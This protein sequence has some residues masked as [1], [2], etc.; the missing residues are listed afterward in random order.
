MIS[1]EDRQLLNDMNRKVGEVHGVITTWKPQFIEKHEAIDKRFE[2]I[3]NKITAFLTTVILLLL[4]VL[5]VIAKVILG[6]DA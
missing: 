4:S 5:G 3:E 6:V 2:S 1:P